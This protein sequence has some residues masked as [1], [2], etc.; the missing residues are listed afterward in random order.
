MV[1]PWITPRWIWQGQNRGV[2][3]AVLWISGC[4]S[5]SICMRSVLSGRVSLWNSDE[6][7]ASFRAAF[8]MDVKSAALA[9][10]RGR[11]RGFESEYGGWYVAKVLKKAGKRRPL[12]PVPM[13]ASSTSARHSFSFF[14]AFQVHVGVQF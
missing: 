7:P 6:Q 1:L 8:L 9:T 14:T 10:K 11:G 12:G 2:D 13:I 4:G 3:V 5:P